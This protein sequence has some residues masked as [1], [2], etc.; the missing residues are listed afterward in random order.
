MVPKVTVKK[1]AYCS[2]AVY[3]GYRPSFAPSTF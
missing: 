3:K 2:D 1:E